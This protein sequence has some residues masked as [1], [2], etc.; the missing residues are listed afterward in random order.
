L[1]PHPLFEKVQASTIKKIK[2]KE[3][4]ATPMQ[5]IQRRIR[6][7]LGRSQRQIEHFRLIGRDRE[8]RRD[9][10]AWWGE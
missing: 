3:F 1:G 4:P 5:R 6:L 7:D 8:L 9:L 2:P 10:L